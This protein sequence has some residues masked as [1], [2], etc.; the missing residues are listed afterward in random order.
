MKKEKENLVIFN[1]VYIIS[2]EYLRE[3]EKIYN[4]TSNNQSRHLVTFYYLPMP[5]I[6]TY[7]LEIFIK[8]NTKSKSSFSLLFQ[9]SQGRVFLIYLDQILIF[10]Q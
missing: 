6:H 8:G 5:A 7:P 3:R 2:Q 4:P 10:I 1:L 9:I